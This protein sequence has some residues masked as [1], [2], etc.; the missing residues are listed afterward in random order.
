MLNSPLL[1]KK[2]CPTIGIVGGV[3]VL[4]FPGGKKA[5]NVPM[6]EAMSTMINRAIKAVSSSRRLRCW[7]ETAEG[8]CTGT[9]VE[10]SGAERPGENVGGIGVIGPPG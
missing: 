8:G 9:T 3:L 7:G 10:R 4:L 5:K 1:I 2:A 6:P